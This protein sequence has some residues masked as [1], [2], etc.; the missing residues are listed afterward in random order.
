MELSE[1]RK[2]IDEIDADIARLFA[3]RMEIALDVA[4]WK[5]EH[6]R[7]TFDPVREREKINNVRRSSPPGLENYMTSLFETMMRLS[8]FRQD[9]INGAGSL[10]DV[11]R[12]AARR[13]PKLFPSDARVACQGIEGAYSQIATTRLF[14]YPEI[15]FCERF[16]GVFRAIESGASRYGV[17]PIENS[18]YGSVI[19]VYD[20]MKKYRF[21]IVRALKLRIAHT[22]LARSGATMGGIRE[23][24]SHQQ[25]LG[26]CREFLASHPEIRVT[27]CSNTAIA[28]RMVAESG[29]DDIAAI[30]AR[31][32]ADLY[33]LSV[34]DD[35]ISDS[36]NN[37]TRFICISRD[38]EIYPGA[39]RMS[40]TS[41]LPHRPG[42]LHTM[43]A[44]FAMLGLNLTKLES[45]PIPGR[46]FEFKF[47]FD[48]EA[49]VYSDDALALISELESE[50]EAFEF[51]G[52]YTEI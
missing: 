21:Y 19:E 15:S 27:P 36:D 50:S 39:S 23:V 33:G 32:C 4:K 46:D 37:Y 28:A 51:L 34:L 48:I 16:E 47:Y 45:R 30:S 11:I 9:A 13:T 24:L 20:L 29:R 5:R 17:L 6:G 26:Q 42:S 25:A 2:R 40:M 49:P 43:L 22:L 44:R 35:G 14:Q 52:S 31:E 8:R 1:C 7:Q 10:A 41:K 18:S 3:E 38:M 12:A